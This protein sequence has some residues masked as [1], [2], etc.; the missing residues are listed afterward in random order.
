M[1]TMQKNIANV[2]RLIAS[3]VELLDEAA[4]FEA[5]H[6]LDNVVMTASAHISP[7]A[8]NR[9]QLLLGNRLPA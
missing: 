1:A 3:T 9:L 8:K 4:D 7:D 2:Q 6:T 5:H